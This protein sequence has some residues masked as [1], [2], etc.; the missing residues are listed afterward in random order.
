[1]ADEVAVDESA[2]DDHGDAPEELGEAGRKALREERRAKTV[3]ERRAAALEQEL[4]QLR[5]SQKG[6]AERAL[7][8][9]RKE[10]A[11]QAS[12]PLA[13]ELARYKVALAKGLS[14]DDLEFLTGDTEEEM[15]ARADKLLE[16]I[17]AAKPAPQF[18]GGPRTP[19]AGTSMN[20]LIRQQ[21]GR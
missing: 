20:D 7:D 5:E 8:Q 21:M 16:R 10:A 9:A 17:G 3:A 12:A 15:A 6:D 18:N 19:A 4:G 14:A 11:D 2:T 1:M 13:K